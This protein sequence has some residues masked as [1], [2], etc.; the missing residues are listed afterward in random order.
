[1]HAHSARDEHSC[2]DK[3]DCR[4][5][6]DR[7]IPK[8]SAECFVNRQTVTVDP[9]LLESRGHASHDQNHNQVETV[10][11]N[12]GRRAQRASIEMALGREKGDRGLLQEL[13]YKKN[14]RGENKESPAMPQTNRTD[15]QPFYSAHSWKITNPSIHERIS[16]VGCRRR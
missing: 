4:Q 3:S 6:R 14:Y 7:S 8:K 10:A 12:N 13:D 11:N 16:R 5:T 1:M 2:S 15:E 9:P